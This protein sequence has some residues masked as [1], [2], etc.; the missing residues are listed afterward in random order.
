LQEGDLNFADVAERYIP[1]P[2]LRRQG[3]YIG[4]VK[5]KQ[6]R[7]EV[8]AAVFAAKPPQLLQPIVSAVGIHLIR[9]EE[10]IESQLDE[11]LYD[12]ILMEMFDLWLDEVN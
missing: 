6:L 1:I 9:V 4:K 3:G 11:R 10:I 7:P 8:S 5:R 12:R 2:E